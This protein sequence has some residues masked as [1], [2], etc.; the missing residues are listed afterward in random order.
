MEDK[1]RLVKCRSCKTLQ[2]YNLWKGKSSEKKVPQNNCCC[3]CGKRSYT[4]E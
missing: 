2:T 3:E 4:N 1:F